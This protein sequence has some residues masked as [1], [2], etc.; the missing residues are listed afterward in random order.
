M[1]RRVAVII[2][3]LGSAWLGA[4][5]GGGGGGSSAPANTPLPGGGAV[6]T[7]HQVCDGSGRLC[8]GLDDLTLAAGESTTYAVTVFTAGGRGQSGVRV[9][10]GDGSNTEITPGSGSTDE[11][12]QLVGS[13]DA[14]FGGQSIITASA[15]D[16]GL[17]VFLRVSIRGGVAPTPDG[18]VTGTV[19]PVTFTPTPKEVDVVTTIYMETSPFVINSEDGGPV[20]VR[21]IAFDANNEPVDDVNLLFDFLPKVGTLRPITTRTRTITDDGGVTLSGVAEIIIQIPPLDAPPGNVTVTAKSPTAEGSVDFRISADESPR[22]VG[23]VLLETSDAQC[24]SD[25]GGA[26]VMRAIVFDESNRPLDKVNVLFLTDQG[27]GRFFPLVEETAEIGNQMGVAEST[28]QIPTGAPVR[29]D[30]TTGAILPYVF[31]ARAGGVEG[32]AQVFVVPGRE[33]CDGSTTTGTGQP[34]SITLSANNRTLRVR[35]NGQLEL[36]QVRAEIKDSGNNE[37]PTTKVRFFLDPATTSTGASLLPANESG[38]ICSV[39]LVTCDTNSGCPDGETCEIDPDNRFISIADQAGNAQIVVRAGTQIGTISVGAEVVSGASASETVPCSHPDDAGLSCIRATSAVLTVTA[40]APGRIALGVNNASVNNQDGNQVTT[41]HATVTDANGNTVGD[42]TPVL[43]SIGS[44]GVDSE[45][46]DRIGVVGF[47]TTNGDAPCDVSQFPAQ[48]AFPVTAQPGVAISCIF[49]PPNLAGADVMV[50]ATSNGVSSSRIVTLPGFISDLIVAP[51]PSQVRV[52]ADAPGVSLITGVVL[53]PL[54]DPVPNVELVF[55]TDPIF[56]NFGAGSAPPW[57]TRVRTDENGIAAASLEISQT[58]TQEG[59]IDVRVYGGG[60]PRDFAARVSVDFTASGT[61][62]G[63]GEPQSVRFV[64]A[65]PSNITVQGAA[66]PDQSIVFFEVVDSSG[67]GLGGIPVDFVVN[68]LGGARVSPS[69]VFTDRDGFAQTAVISGTRTSPIQVTASVDVD[70]NGSAELVARSQVVNVVGGRPSAGRI[71]V[72]TEFL[73]IAGRVFSGIENDVIV[74][75]NDRFGNAVAPNTVVSVASNGGSIVRPTATDESG[76]ARAVLVSGPTDS[77]TGIVS[78]LATMIGEEAFADT[79]GNGVRDNNESFEDIAEPFIDANGNGQFDLDQPLET[80]VDTNGNGVWDAAQNPGVWDQ[81]AIIFTQADVTFSG[82]VVASVEPESAELFFGDRAEFTLTVGDA[83]NNALT[84][85]ATVRANIGSLGFGI[86]ADQIVAEIPDIQ[87]FGAPVDGVNFFEFGMTVDPARS[88]TSESFVYTI[89]ISGG[90]SGGPGS[91]GDLTLF[92]PVKFNPRPTQTPTATPLPTDTTTPEPTTTA[93]PTATPTPTVEATATATITFTPQ[94]GAM[95][96][97]QAEPSSIGVRGSGIAE[98]SVLTFRVTDDR[99]VPIA[100]ATVRFSV[101]SLGGETLSPGE[102]VTAADGTVSTTL[103]SG[104]RTASVRVRA[105]LVEDTSIFTQSTSLII[106]GAPPAADRFSLATQFLNVA[107]G[108]TL[109]IED[110]ITAF[111][112]DR[113]G[114]AVPEGTAVS[115][116]SNASSV[117]NP[118]ASDVEGR[119]SATLITEGGRFPPDGIVRVLGFTRGEEPFVDGNGDGVFND[120]ETFIDVPEPFIDSDGNGVYDPGNPFDMFVDVNDNGVWDIAQGPGVWDNNA[121]IYDVVPVTFS[122]ATQV[123]LTPFSGFTIPD[124]GGET[125]TLLISDS[126]NNPIVGGSTVAITPGEGLTLQGIPAS[127]TIPDAT[128]FGQ[129]IGGVNAFTFTVIDAEPGQGDTDQSVEVLVTIT[130]AP[131]TNA[132]GGNGSVSVSR[133]GTLQAPPVP[134]A[135]PTA[136]ATATAT[137]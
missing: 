137:P 94:P 73:N 6:S 68:G 92:A 76:V 58:N 120:G 127:F 57:I 65:E 20:T 36:S 125:F 44:L 79:N 9:E 80:F 3:F 83:D 18:T 112:N 115:F 71:S 49:F 63:V 93:P 122:G 119:A 47:P 5:G 109:G 52:T 113:F 88:T 60:I 103:T 97:V 34:S 62:P 67:E 98:Q 105:E 8:L 70:G 129:T 135:M 116:L 29:V 46:R 42:G 128:T 2:A 40:G 134:T 114:N 77:P 15:P 99:A 104:R 13:V 24:G 12:G 133:I 33:P 118:S 17:E 53:D 21:A 10:V 38:G 96:F 31:R 107:G 81:D 26:I 45:V 123:S 61:I 50:V 111:L 130:S 30:P 23:T 126:L 37:V 90:I 16:L 41:I 72:A 89:T 54:G 86:T 28:L 131:T 43:I 48:V 91:N 59:S 87:T 35:G 56:G 108:V 19:I 75:V 4:C 64:S 51:N 25:S 39:T 110:V 66:G 84:S 132:P 78:V 74:F 95:S 32:T 100:G 101:Q 55:E 102:A 27:L 85:N 22:P 121:L 1:S 136:T 11:N 69:R 7:N 14:L 82:R 124:G 117:V 106:V